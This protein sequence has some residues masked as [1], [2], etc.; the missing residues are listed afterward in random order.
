MAFFYALLAELAVREKT[1]SSFYISAFIKRISQRLF[2]IERKNLVLI[3]T[4]LTDT[5][6]SVKKRTKNLER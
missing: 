3:L 2:F 5:I 6:L 1:A 4:A